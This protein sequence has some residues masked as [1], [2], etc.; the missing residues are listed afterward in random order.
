M[1]KAW[2]YRHDQN[3]VNLGQNLFQYARRGGWINGD[4]DAFA[5]S[6]DVLHRAMQ[7][8]IVFPMHEKRIRSGLD[9]FLNKQIRIRDHQVRFQRQI[10][11][12]PYRSDNRGAH[13]DIGNKM[14]VHH[15]D[16]YS[17]GSSTL[18]L[19][20]LSAESGKVR[21]KYRWGDF[22][23]IS[24]YCRASVVVGLESKPFQEGK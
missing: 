3:L 17:I 10:R 15:V 21:G 23:A 12:S 5:T 4:S 18:G 2:V 19:A 1:S 13:G 22:G 14:T 11:H 7:V 9:E 24:I 16:V 8:D 6:P 20:Y